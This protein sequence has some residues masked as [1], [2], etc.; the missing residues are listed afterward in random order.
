MCTI[1]LAWR[2]LEDAPAVLAANR[3]ELL[4]R[5][6]LPPSR[7]AEHPPIYGGRDVLAGGTWL[8]LTPDGRI[9][10]VTNRRTDDSD[11]VVRNPALR[12]RGEL[13]VAIL[14]SADM[15]AALEGIRP[16][17]YNP[18]NVV[19]VDSDL[20]LVGH[21]T[22]GGHVEL[23]A[24]QPGFH[25]LSVHDVDDTAHV[26]ERR[27]RQMLEAR[28]AGVTSAEACAA[29]MTSVLRDHGADASDPRDAVC[30]HGET[31]GT[32]SASLV[33]ARGGGRPEYS[34]APGRPCTTLFAD[35]L[36]SVGDGGRDRV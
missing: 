10:A 21:W 17:D 26:K 18:F 19:A 25:V 11:E 30:I 7:L 8:A 34:H 15:R 31:Y 35:V 29:A 20:A 27:V 36:L 12:S 5:P 4:A 33:I 23:I 16:S 13:P 3:D 32:V 6:S 22:E 9:A 2:C 14:T 28:T 1:L 24:L